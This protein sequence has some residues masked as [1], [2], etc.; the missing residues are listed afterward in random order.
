MRFAPAV[1]DWT[2]IAKMQCLTPGH[3]RPCAE[4][5]AQ[6]GGA[7]DTVLGVESADLHLRPVSRHKEHVCMQP[8]TCLHKRLLSLFFH[9]Q[10]ADRVLLAYLMLAYLMTLA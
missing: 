4:Y 7:L 2:Q 6:L 10:L 3:H 5:N 8:T 9:S 1:C